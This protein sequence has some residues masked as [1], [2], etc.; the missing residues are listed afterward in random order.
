[1]HRDSSA[2]LRL[3]QAVRELAASAARLTCGAGKLAQVVCCLGLFFAD[4]L[5]GNATRA[6]IRGRS[7]SSPS[8]RVLSST[9]NVQRA[10]ARPFSGA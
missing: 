3:R 4:S 8:A 6:G 9:D 1:M 5:R 10:A 2:S 7:T